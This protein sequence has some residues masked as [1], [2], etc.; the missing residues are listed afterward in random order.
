MANTS[1]TFR[2]LNAFADGFLALR[3]CFLARFSAVFFLVELFSV[4]FFFFGFFFFDFFAVDFLAI[5]NTP[6]IKSQVDK[7]LGL[8]GITTEH[9]IACRLVRLLACKKRD[10]QSRVLRRVVRHQ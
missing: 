9:S 8:P 4:D 5:S 10:R 3:V 7:C 6:I 2:G 1:P